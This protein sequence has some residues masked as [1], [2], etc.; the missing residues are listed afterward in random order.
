M[1]MELCKNTDYFRTERE[2][3]RAFLKPEYSIPVHTHEFWE[4]NIV[5]SGKGRHQIEGQEFPAVPGSVF[6]IP[7]MISHGYAN[8]GSLCVFHLLFRPEFLAGCERTDELEMLLE[9]EPF[10]RRNFHAPLFLCMAPNHLLSIQAEFLPLL[11]GGVLDYD[12]ADSVR[13]HTSL[14]NLYWM[15]HLLTLQMEQMKNSASFE[16]ESAVI[17]AIQYIH[18]NFSKPIR[19]EDLCRLTFLSKS[20]FLRSF[21]AVCG[22]T[23]I[24]YLIDYRVKTALEMIQSGKRKTDVAQECGFYDL[25]HMEKSIRAYC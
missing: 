19:I 4:L 22:R 3:V 13:D 9:I 7:P 8:E 12:G 6:V 18:E 2:N 21:K 5:F 14:K 23:P 11:D 17:D 16:H 25:S 10:L 24:Q 1:Q 15:A 20:T